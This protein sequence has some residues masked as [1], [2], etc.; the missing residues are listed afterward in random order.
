MKLYSC[1]KVFDVM[2]IEGVKIPRKN[3][4]GKDDLSEHGKPRQKA[5]SVVLGQN[6]TSPGC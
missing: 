4:K 1:G 3:S 6:A 2:V 5:G